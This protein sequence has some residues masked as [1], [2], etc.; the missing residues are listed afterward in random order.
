MRKIRDI[1][2]LAFGEELSRRR[3]NASLEIPLT[4]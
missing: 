2:R 3:V 1:L 4:T